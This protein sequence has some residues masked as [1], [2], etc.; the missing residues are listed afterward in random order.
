MYYERREALD[1]R[2]A[3]LERDL[4]GVKTVHAKHS[5]DIRVLKSPMGNK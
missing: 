4:E 1:R 3:K 2:D 5:E